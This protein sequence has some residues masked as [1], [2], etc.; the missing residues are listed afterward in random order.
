[1]RRRAQKQREMEERVATLLGQ[2]METVMSNSDDKDLPPKRDPAKMQLYNDLKDTFK[3]FDRDN[4]AQLI[5]NEYREAW[6]FLSLPGDA[7]EIKAAFDK[8]DIDRSGAVDFTEF[9]FSIMGEEA[10]NYG[11]LADLEMLQTLLTK[12]VSGGGKSAVEA[13]ANAQKGME[14]K[15]AQIAQLQA[16]LD[17]LRNAESGDQFNDLVQ[18]M[19]FKAGVTRIGPLTSDE[20][21]NEIDAVFSTSASGGGMDRK[22]FQEVVNSKKMMELR[23]RKLIAEIQAD[24]WL[25]SKSPYGV[26][27]EEVAG[28]DLASHH[29]AEE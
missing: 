9:S 21:N 28:R 8:V 11:Y 16:E 1:M 3:A 24:Y 7:N 22:T 17:R 10:G 19:M 26:D 13:L 4:N 25:E 23:L 27:D 29:T 2:L 6:K 5:F 18:R 12:L 14:G 20:L 15:D